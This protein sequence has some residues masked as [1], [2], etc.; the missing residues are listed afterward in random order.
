MVGPIVDIWYYD[1]PQ[2]GRVAVASY[3]A[4]P[5]IR[6]TPLLIS[7]EHTKLQFFSSHEIDALAM[8]SGYKTTIRRAYELLH[9]GAGR[10]SGD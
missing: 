6:T 8:P 9:K 5:L 7:P 4:R 1:I 2:E 10:E 3:L